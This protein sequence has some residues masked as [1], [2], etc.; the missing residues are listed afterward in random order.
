VRSGRGTRA[1]GWDE[2]AQLAAL[3]ASLARQEAGKHGDL[4]ANRAH[5]MFSEWCGKLA[6]ACAAVADQERRSIEESD[7]AITPV[8][9]VPL[10]PASRR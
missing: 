9:G 1:D 4:E 7:S 2:A 3:W 6:R 8:R 10:P 5:R